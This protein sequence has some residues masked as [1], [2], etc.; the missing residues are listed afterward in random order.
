M[1]LAMRNGTIATA[2]VPF[3]ADAGVDEGMIVQVGGDVPA[4]TEIDATGK[5]VLAGGVDI[6]THLASF[7]SDLTVD[8]FESG[9]RAAAAGGAVRRPARRWPGRGW[10]TVT[11]SWIV[12]HA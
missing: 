9:S 11:G 8:D 7:G 4:A 12:P 1:Q 2:D 10:E 6:H 5:L 3:R